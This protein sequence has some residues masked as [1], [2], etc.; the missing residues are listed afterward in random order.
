RWGTNIPRLVDTAIGGWQVSVLQVATVGQPF[1]VY[2]QR[3]T[4]PVTGVPTTG[5]YAQFNGTDRG[6]GSVGKRGDGVYYFTPS[7]VSQFGFPGAFEIGN[8][9]RNAFRDPSFFETDMA[10]VKT[11]AITE[12]HRIDF[13]IEGYNVFNHPNFGLTN[14][15]LNPNTPSTFGKFS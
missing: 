4:F 2:S 10:L 15:N 3:L 14:G 9:G 11:F 5:T 1:S 8:A 6:I 13:K 12:R 7:Q